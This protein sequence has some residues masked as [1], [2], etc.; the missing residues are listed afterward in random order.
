MKG[1]TLF[2]IILGTVAIFGAFLWEGGT[3]ATLFLIPAMIIV[4]GGTIA[5]GLAGS[6]FEMIAKMPVLFRITIN[7]KVYNWEEILDQLVRLTSQARK[8]GIL[9]LDEKIKKIEHPFMKKMFEVVIDGVDA[10]NFQH[11]AEVELNSITE[12]HM[13]NIGFFNKLGGYSPTMGIIGT[14]MGLIATFAKAGS[15]PNELIKHIATAFI[16]TLWGIFMANIVWLPIAD[17]LR[18]LH[19]KEMKLNNFVI[20]GV[21]GVMHGET[22]SV[23]L[24]RLAS[25]FPA[26]QQ[27]EIMKRLDRLKKEEILLQSQPKIKEELP[28]QQ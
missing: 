7:P 10:N 2:G 12:R 19:E 24:T 11:I 9:S 25:A 26:S 3:V 1:S 27:G 23:I 16:A 17:K 28:Q 21:L 8:E 18:Y 13:E 14:V 15:D 6:S 4:L 5:A 22:P 20:N